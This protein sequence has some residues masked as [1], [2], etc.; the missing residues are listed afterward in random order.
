MQEPFIGKRADVLN[1]KAVFLMCRGEEESALRLWEEGLS[2]KD[3]HFDIS[4]NFILYKWK[5]AQF[6][7]EDVVEEMK[8]NVI[9][10]NTEKSIGLDGLINIAIGEKNEGMSIIKE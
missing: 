2:M 9:A 3:S 10:A 4:T 5:S 1:K 8:R 6:T 7:D